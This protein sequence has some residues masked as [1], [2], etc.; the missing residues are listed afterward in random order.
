MFLAFWMY[1]YL[2]P[3]L[4]CLRTGR[5][6]GFG[7]GGWVGLFLNIKLFPVRSM[8]DTWERICWFSTR[9]EPRLILQ[10]SV[11]SPHLQGLPLRSLSGTSSLFWPLQSATLG[12][13]IRWGESEGF[14][15]L[16]FS[17]G[18]QSASPSHVMAGSKI[19]VADEGIEW[20]AILFARG[21]YEYYWSPSGE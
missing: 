1:Q 16:L 2:S 15:P 5:A 3:G 17:Q 14:M 4:G 8:Y 7:K 12:S 9:E 20:G 21:E 10:C 6:L 19:G 11:A 13:R 18:A